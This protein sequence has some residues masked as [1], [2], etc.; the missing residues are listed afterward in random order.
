MKQPTYKLRACF[1]TCFVLLAFAGYMRAEGKASAEQ[2]WA[3]VQS[4][5]GAG[6]GDLDRMS[7][8]EQIEAFDRREERIRLTNLAFYRNYPADPRRWD[9]ALTLLRHAPRFIKDWTDAG[10]PVRDEEAAAAWKL[11]QQEIGSDM[12]AAYSSLPG[13]VRERLDARPIFD[14]IGG[15]FRKLESGKSVDWAGLRRRVDAHLA[16]HP[17]EP[18][19]AGIVSRFMG[20]FERAHTATETRVAWRALTLNPVVRESEM[21]A[22][23]LEV[24]ERETGKPMELSFT[25]ADGRE[26]DLTK[27]RGK[28]VLI[29]F[30]ATWCGPCIAAFPHMRE[31]QARY[32][33]KDVVLLGVTSLQGF[34]IDHKAADPK[35]RKKD[36]S[37][38]EAE[39]AMMT[40]W[41]KEMEVTWPIVVTKQNCFNPDFAV[42]GIPHMALIDPDGKVYLNNLSP[43]DKDL[44]DKIDALLAK[45]NR[46][47]PARSEKK[48]EGQGG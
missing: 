11:T 46:P 7:R 15:L 17:T 6:P 1:C 44:E 33:G 3:E 9:A 27:L 29:D 28:V 41:I 38:P 2:D 12:T 25:A 42:G 48:E 13:R 8:R 34:V 30:W 47:V 4:A 37:T 10:Q 20:M 45:F 5:A 19:I 39:L 16:K 36:A 26:V 40:P 14:E 32:Q 18:G 43:W 21:V 31:M 22:K 23:R 24:I 35:A